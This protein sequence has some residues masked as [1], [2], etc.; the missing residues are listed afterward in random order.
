METKRDKHEPKIVKQ[1]SLDQFE[2]MFP[3]EQSCK[4]Y[5]LDQRWPN[6]VRCPRCNN[7]KV[8][9]LKFKPFHWACKACAPN[10]RQPY[11]F[12][13]LVGTVFE[14]T[15][16]PLR[17]WFKVLHL[18][19]VSKKGVSALQIHRMI[20]SGSYR[21]AW[22]ICMRLRAGLKD[23]NFRQLMGI[24]EIDETLIGGKAEN[25]H[26]A[27]RRRLKLAGSKGKTTV[28]GAI[29]RKGN[30]VCQVIERTDLPTLDRFVRKVVNKEKVELVAT[31][32]HG[33][34]NLLGSGPDALPHEVVKHS[35]GEYVRGIVH[36]NTI[37]G[38]WSLLKRG[39][40]G[41]Y[42]SVS[43]KYL[44]LYLNEFQYRFNNRKNPDIFRDSI[45][46]C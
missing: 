21:T 40:V 42:H 18:M 46:G 39:V 29:A 37:E 32:E 34:Y 6:G 23:P 31:D 28:I 12:S 16:Y 27:K 36:T 8:Y 1:L 20:D 9:T 44:P 41:T 15:N 25:M 19:L 22:F 45:A 33:G 3:D 38:F 7:E 30:V 11:R 14:N 4:Q 2:A 43:K 10:P 24:V 5:L 13:V 26:L 35:G 17:T